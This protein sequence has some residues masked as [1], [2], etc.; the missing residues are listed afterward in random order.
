MWREGKA[1]S[2]GLA[3]LSTMV[4]AQSCCSLLFRSAAREELLIY[5]IKGL[6]FWIAEVPTIRPSPFVSV[7]AKWR[8]WTRMF[9][10][11]IIK[12]AS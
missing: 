6:D 8:Q 10:G 2:M 11:I 3:V 1:D 12:R 7:V 4:L 9:Y 5:E